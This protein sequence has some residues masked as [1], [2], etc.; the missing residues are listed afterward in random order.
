MKTIS[1]RELHNNTGE[2]IRKVAEE[3]EIIVTDRG[4]AVATVQPYKKPAARKYTWANRPLR[5]GYAAA[6][7]AG[8]L[9]TG[10]DSTF[11]IS[12]D[13]TSRDNSVAGIEGIG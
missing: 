6:M 2:W 13:R 11:Y 3:E 4:T 7:K 8:K 12:Q 5:P 1:L 9:K 10:G